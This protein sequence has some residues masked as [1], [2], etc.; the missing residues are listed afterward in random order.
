[1]WSIRSYGQHYVSQS[2]CV[3]PAQQHIGFALRNWPVC[4]RPV[5]MWPF[6]ATCKLECSDISAYNRMR[7]LTIPM[8][9]EWGRGEFFLIS[10]N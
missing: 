1:M 3:G 7:E 6:N 8:A 2:E 10:N 9:W 5:I 4:H